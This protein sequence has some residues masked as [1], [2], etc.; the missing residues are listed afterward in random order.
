MCHLETKTQKTY[1]INMTFKMV[2]KKSVIH[3]EFIKLVVTL[4]NKIH[5]TKTHNARHLHRVSITS[6]IT[7]V[8]I[9]L[10][11]VLLIF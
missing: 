10:S 9:S 11:T 3:T 2:S 7:T 4:E 6:I 8:N 5:N 1:V